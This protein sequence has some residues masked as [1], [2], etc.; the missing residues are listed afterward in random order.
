MVK[1]FRM[2]AGRRLGRAE[3]HLVRHP[4]SVVR[5]GSLLGSAKRRAGGAHMTPTGKVRL[6]NR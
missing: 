2:I 5:S 1:R 6:D 4:W 3:G